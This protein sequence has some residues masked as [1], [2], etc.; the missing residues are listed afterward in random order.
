MTDFQGEMNRNRVVVTG[1]GAVTPVGINV[2]DTWESLIQGKSG[3]DRIKSFDTLDLET[4]IAAEVSNEFEALVEERVSRRQRK[5]MTRMTKMTLAATFDAIDESGLDFN[6][7]DK[8]R[9]AVILGII[10]TGYNDNERNKSTSNYVVKTMPNAPSA[11]ISLLYGIEGAN[12]NV[13]TACASS[14]YAISIASHLI[15]SG[16]YDVVICGGADSTI[17]YDGIKGFNQVMAMSTNNENPQK[18]SKPFSKDRDGFIMG[19]GAGILVL[20]S[21]SFAKGRNANIHSEL[22]G[23]A[24][25]SEAQDI[26]APKENGAGMLITMEKAIQKAG[27]HKDEIDYINAHGTSTYL[28]DKYETFAIKSCFKDRAKKIPVS[29]TKSMTGHT[30]AAGGAIESIVTILSINNSVLTPTI[31]YDEPDPELDLDYVPNMA[32][33]ADIRIGLSN[34]FGFGG[35][36]A[37]LIYKGYQE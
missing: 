13:S 26:V 4:T 37:T 6:K 32:R 34:S 3:I 28:N 1:M 25:T 31:N 8:S 9:V 11:W 2:K 33:K 17:S 30:I 29:S 21:L 24:I 27:C 22:L 19:E 5:Q 10:T 18:A 23:Y 12:F 16:I 15:E 36:N 14:A 35:H 20:E 7:I